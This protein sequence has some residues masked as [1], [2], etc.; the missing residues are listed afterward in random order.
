MEGA[1]AN[2]GGADIAGSLGREA[3]QPIGLSV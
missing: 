1:A 2:D 3:R